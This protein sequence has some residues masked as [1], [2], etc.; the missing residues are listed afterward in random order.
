[1]KNAKWFG[2][3]ICSPLINFPNDS[4][5][6]DA[7][8]PMELHLLLAMVNLLYKNL[9]SIWSE[10]KVWPNALNI[11]LQ[12][13]HAGHF[14][15]NH[16]QKLLKNVDI[17]LKQQLH[18]RYFLLLVNSGNL[19]RWLQHVL[20]CSL[21]KITKNTLK[22][23]ETHPLLLQQPSHQRSM[24]CST[25]CLSSSLRIKRS[26]PVLRTNHRCTPFKL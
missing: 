17:L 5:I 8:P 14:H 13:F 15:G 2:N 4:L 20:E 19:K 9:T 7:T 18:L 11:P 10:Y 1:M 12:P 24:L 16:C 26:W 21:I 23:S 6:L 25:M 22:T 3:V